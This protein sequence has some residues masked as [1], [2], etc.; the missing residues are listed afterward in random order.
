MMLHLRTILKAVVSLGL[1]GYLIYLADPV[2]ILEV[3]DQVWYENG[4][5]YLS[6][7]AA[8]FL[9]SLLILSFRWQILVSGYGLKIHTRLLF[10]YYLIGLFFNNFLPT[11]IGGDVLRIYNL[12]QSSGD[13]TVSFASVM[14]ERLLGI[15]STLILA[16]I[17]IILLRD[18][19]SNNLLLY[20][21]LGMISLVVLFFAMAFS[22]NLAA[23]IEKITMR[24]TLF[25]LGDRIQK[26]LDAIRFYSD[27]KVIYLKI[28]IISLAGQ[29]LIIIKAYCLSLALG[30]E[31][32]P[33]Y[34]FLVVPIAIILSML[35]SING[36]GF[37]DGAYVI[38]LAKVGVS[39]AAALSLS[40]LT[41]FIPIL[42]SISG[43]VLFMLQKK[44]V[45]E[46]EVNIVEKSIT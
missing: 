32:N 23:P 39:K 7:S 28:L 40:F 17:S 6:I 13:R 36:I 26:F 33:I 12:I 20:L 42:I 46:E 27:S 15:S 19:I 44:I 25:R 1:L 45:R 2:K 4:V 35:P 3:L 18:E 22:K 8:L 41:L 16:L 14:T 29:I 11:G 21:V 9:L 10:K 37:R 38:L 34:M 24:I 43:G 5:I 30:I 31:V